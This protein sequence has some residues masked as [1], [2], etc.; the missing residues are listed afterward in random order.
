VI[1]FKP[2]RE[3][4]AWAAGFFDGEGSIHLG[5][6]YPGKTNRKCPRIGIGQSGEHAPALLKRFQDAVGGLG[7]IGGPY[8]KYGDKAFNR[9]PRYQFAAGGFPSVQAITAMLWPFLGPAKRDKIKQVFTGY[10]EEI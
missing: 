7:S 4:L 3:E 9:L 6:A 8:E 2:N 5:P 1:V 10:R